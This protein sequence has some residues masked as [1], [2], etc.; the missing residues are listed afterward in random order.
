MDTLWSLYERIIADW[1]SATGS[2]YAIFALMIYMFA[3][4]HWVVQNVRERFTKIT[5]EEMY[6]LFQLEDTNEPARKS[7]CAC[8]S[9]KKYKNELSDISWRFYLVYSPF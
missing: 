2:D 4:L 9:G 6:E 5:M 7:L 8:G 3:G 1:H